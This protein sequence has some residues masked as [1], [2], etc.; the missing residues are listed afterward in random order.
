MRAAETLAAPVQICAEE[1]SPPQRR[2]DPD[3]A[4][5]AEAATTFR[6]RCSTLLPWVQSVLGPKICYCKPQ[7]K[8]WSF[9]N[10]FKKRKLNFAKVCLSL[11]VL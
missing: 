1:E 5:A 6:V 8:V 4:A 3:E 9:I 7:K 2:R 10:N 11:L